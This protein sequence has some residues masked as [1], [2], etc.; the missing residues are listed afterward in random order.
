MIFGHICKRAN[1]CSSLRLEETAHPA[2][3]LNFETNKKARPLTDRA[4]LI[5]FMVS[6]LTDHR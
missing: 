2:R 5:I 1:K 3:E 6:S 4:F